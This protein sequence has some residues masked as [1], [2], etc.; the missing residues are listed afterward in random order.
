MVARRAKPVIR[1]AGRPRKKPGTPT[2]RKLTEQIRYKEA[3]NWDKAVAHAHAE[4]LRPMT[5]SVT[6][7]WR[8]AP[9]SVPEPNRVTAL[10]NVMG[11]WLRYRTHAP[12]VWAYARE[13]ASRKGVHL[14]LLVHVP[15][16]LIDDFTAAMT[17]WIKAKADSYKSSAV[18]VKPVRPGTFKTLRSYLFK[19]GD[20]DVHDAFDVLPEHRARRQ[21]GYPVPGKRLRVSHSIDATA[22]SRHAMPLNSVLDTQERH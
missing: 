21:S 12:P 15:H 17:G 14:H 7:Q 1:P 16:H 20:D 8:H 5:V 9:S 22:R 11:V 2:H 6:V 13:S 18:D 19:D 10:I 3:A 4:L